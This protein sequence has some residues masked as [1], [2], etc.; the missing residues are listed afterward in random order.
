M[1]ATNRTPD[2]TLDHSD[3]R[4]HPSR[5][6]WRKSRV[7][8]LCLALG[9]LAGVSIGVGLGS[10]KRASG[11]LPSPGL[12]ANATSI[13][14]T[15]GSPQERYIELQVA[16]QAPGLAPIPAPARVLVDE[17][18]AG[19]VFAPVA[20]RVEQVVVHLGQEVKP[21]DRLVAIRSS[22]LPELGREAESARAAL[23]VKSALVERLRDLVAL[24]A[25]PE[26][27]LI[28]AQQEKREIELTLK[29]AEGKR[30]SLHLGHLDPSG[31]FWLTAPRKGTVVERAALMGMEVGPDR[32][33]PLV[34]IAELDEVIVVADVLGSDTEDLKSG[35]T[36]QVSEVNARATPV[37]GKIEYVADF[38][39]PIRRTIAVR[40]R[41][42]NPEHRLRPNAFVQVTFATHTAP[43][44]QV[45]SEA[46]VTDD[47]KSIVF[48]KTGGS[49]KN[50]RLER[51][52]V[53]IGR[54]RDGKTEIL[55]GLTEG[56]TFVSR[57]ALLL[58]NALD[59]AS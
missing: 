13:V 26:K 46:V 50:S 12:V 57:G 2:E 48:I 21:G 17:T 20:G 32:T 9:L 5:V 8:L 34:Q 49:D 39:D 43:A 44:V 42:P 22:S 59:I 47:Q 33:E 38:V 24:R 31:L 16:K 37:E 41:V 4:S 56:Q 36:A 51:R 10:S 19:P 11:P 1:S 14:L 25:V 52:E 40:I 18:R 3:D 7:A 29:A 45:P 28:V 15:Q 6:G 58:L 35:Q 53:R 23:A 30:R 55:G 27:D 54:S